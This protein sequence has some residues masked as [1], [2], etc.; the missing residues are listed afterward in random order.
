[1][2]LAV[3]IVLTML[4]FA[5]PQKT[6]ADDGTQITEVTP[7][8][9]GEEPA[10]EPEVQEPTETEFEKK[11][12]ISSISKQVYTGKKIKPAVIVKMA[13]KTLKEGKDYK[14]S[15]TNNQNVGKA[16]VTVTGLGKYSG[17]VTKTF[18]IIPKG[19]TIKQ[20]VPLSKA[21]I[22]NWNRQEKKM[23]KKRITGY[24][25][26]LAT[27]KKFS[28]NVKKVKVAD[29]EKAAQMIKKLKGGKKYF[30][31]IRTYMTIDKKDYFSKWSPVKTINTRP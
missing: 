11:A 24:Q 3:L 10:T 13:K 27:N 5:R 23:S 31:R 26:Q 29:Y 1:M 30:V 8:A 6:L 9:E 20:M 14:V 22:I 12:A 25:V 17:T 18:S 7:P 4:P 28:K 21:L 16:T 15:Y 19:T 2:I